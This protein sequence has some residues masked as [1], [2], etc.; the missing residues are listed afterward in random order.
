MGYLE[1]AE[2][3]KVRER[4]LIVGSKSGC[5]PRRWVQTW[6]ESMTRWTW[7]HGRYFLDMRSSRGQ[8]MKEI[9]VKIS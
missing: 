4:F 5:G 3:F 9:K 6:D 7:Y 8:V 1:R 2:K